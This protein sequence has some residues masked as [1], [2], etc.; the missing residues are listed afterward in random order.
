M[1]E[2]TRVFFGKI[3]KL[4]AL[5]EQ[6][7]KSYIYTHIALIF[8]AFIARYRI[9]SLAS[10]IAFFGIISLPAFVLSSIWMTSIISRYISFDTNLTEIVNRENNDMSIILS[11]DLYQNLRII[12]GEILNNE[13]YRSYS[14]AAII[15]L[16][17]GSQI[18]RIYVASICIIYGTEKKH[19]LLKIR[20]ITFLMHIFYIIMLLFYQITISYLSL[21]IISL[22]RSTLIFTATILGITAIL[23][24]VVLTSIYIMAEPKRKLREHIIGAFISFIMFIFS[25]IL[26]SSIMKYFMRTLKLFGLFTIP[27][28]ILIWLYL[29]AFSALTGAIYNQISYDMRLIFKKGRLTRLM[30][31]P[32]KKLENSDIVRLQR[33]RENVLSGF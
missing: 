4:I 11:K 10:E 33:Y 3:S 5:T 13:H 23:A 9:S 2:K 19:N 14:I 1:L 32:V 17:S 24:V 27:L 12:I 6:R 29:L 21:R 30:L 28:S 20:F 7:S 26:F 22:G 18:I 25:S 16:F 8:Y 31:K 15:L